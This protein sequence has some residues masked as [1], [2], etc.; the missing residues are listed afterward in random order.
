MALSNLRKAI[1]ESAPTGQNK[2]CPGLSDTEIDK[3]S[4]NSPDLVHAI[5]SAETVWNSIAPDIKSKDPKALLDYLQE[6]I[7]NFYPPDSRAPYVALAAKGPWVVTTEGSVVYDSGGYGMLGLGHAPDIIQKELLKEDFMANVM[8]ASLAQKKATSVL[9]HAIGEKKDGGP[10]AAFA[11][12]NSGS[13]ANNLALRLTELYASTLS[14][15]KSPQG[16]KT[17][18][19]TLKKGFHGRTDAPA[20]VSDSSSAAYK[21]LPIMGKLLEDV[22]KVEM[23]DVAGIKAAFAEAKK[24]NTFICAAVV[25][26][27]MGEGNAGLSMTPEFYKELRKCTKEEKSLLIIDS[28]QAGLRAHGVLSIVDYPEMKGIEG[29]DFETF[30]K[31]INGGQFPISVIAMTKEIKALSV[32]G[33]VVYGNTMTSN[34]KAMNIVSAVLKSI[35]PEVQ[36]NIVKQGKYFLDRLT[37]L[38]KRYPKIID[39]AQGTGLLLSMRL[40]SEFK[41]EGAGGVEVKMRRAGVNVIHSSGNALRFTPHFK[42]TNEEIDLII[43]V[44][45]SVIN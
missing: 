21:N 36:Q 39:S 10:Y 17:G 25:E 32:S 7:L 28:I 29:P 43:R 18:L 42:V 38:A 30:S 24:N 44:L 20:R 37:D 31:A 9:K 26:P 5:S 19:L 6:H 40:K 45:E 15:E 13:E 3:F 27:V 8:T 2:I 34:P 14:G 4:K 35:T 22:Y 1:S 33:P 12:L 23:N 16:K 41:V 11:F